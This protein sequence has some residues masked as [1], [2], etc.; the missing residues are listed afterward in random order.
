MDNIAI[1]LPQGFRIQNDKKGLDI[2]TGVDLDS[3]S[4]MKSDYPILPLPAI[5]YLNK[6]DSETLYVLQA[7]RD[8]SKLDESLVYDSREYLQSPE[9]FASYFDGRFPG[10]VKNLENL[11]SN[12]K[13]DLEENLSLP[14]FNKKIPAVE[15]LRDLAFAGLENKLAI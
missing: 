10:S 8:G 14:V 7:V 3:N 15:E 1:A 6:T 4:N 12:I 13:Y 9:S 2:Y 11:V 5:R